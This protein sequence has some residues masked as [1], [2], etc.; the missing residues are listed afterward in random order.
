MECRRGKTLNHGRFESPLRV[1][2]ITLVQSFSSFIPVDE[3]EWN[4]SCCS[5][6]F[7]G[8]RYEKTAERSKVCPMLPS[9]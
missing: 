6:I 9:N 4:V 2:P 8:S 7:F 3:I 1:V 5:V